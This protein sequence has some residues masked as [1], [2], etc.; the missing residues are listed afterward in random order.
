M[1]RGR[2]TRRAHARRIEFNHARRRVT[3]TDQR[4][5]PH[6]WFARW[7]EHRR[8]KRQEAIEREYHAPERLSA[9]TRA[10]TDADNH[11]RRWS[12]YL[13]GGGNV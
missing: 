1:R 3:M 9:T 5:T 2:A 11:A 8:V 12:S 6:G 7:R 10:Y 4:R 13:G